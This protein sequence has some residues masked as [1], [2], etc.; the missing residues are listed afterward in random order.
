MVAALLIWSCLMFNRMAVHC[1]YCLQG[2]TSF[3]DPI[4]SWHLQGWAGFSWPH[5]K[6][7]QTGICS[8]FHPPN[9][10]LPGLFHQPSDGG[11]LA[12]M[13]PSLVCKSQ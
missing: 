3:I 8:P 11:G 5:L 12:I 7:V 9:F 2:Q 1:P 13:F 10:N 4:K 6:I